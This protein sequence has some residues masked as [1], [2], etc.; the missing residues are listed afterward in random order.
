MVNIAYKVNNYGTASDIVNLCLLMEGVTVKQQSFLINPRETIYGQ[1]VTIVGYD[2]SHLLELRAECEK[3]SDSCSLRFTAALPRF[4][5]LDYAKLFIMPKGPMVIQKESEITMNWVLPDIMELRDWVTQNI[6]YRYDETAHGVSDYWQLP[7]ETLA[8]ETGDSEDFSILLC[9]LLRANGYGPNDV[10]VMVGES[11]TG[12]TGHA[13]VVCRTDLGT[14]W[15]IEPQ[16]IT[17]I[18][19]IWN[20]LSGQ[21]ADL[22]GYKAY[23]KFND[24]E[25]HRIY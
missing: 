13:W 10:Y 16:R 3:T 23:C 4:N 22:S 25:F 1:S 20:I 19:V 24:A 21:I 8:L 2:T 17:G 12:Q 9:S 5:P 14:W 7:C 18:D 11:N 15:T 6:R